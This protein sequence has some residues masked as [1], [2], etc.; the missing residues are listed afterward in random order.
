[1]DKDIRLFLLLISSVPK[2]KLQI[3]RWNDNTDSEGNTTMCL[4]VS[5]R[6]KAPTSREV[7]AIKE[8]F[9]TLEDLEDY[10]F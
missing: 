4:K 5:A 2:S 6:R 8:K 3:E 9:K 10:L 1:M 7:E